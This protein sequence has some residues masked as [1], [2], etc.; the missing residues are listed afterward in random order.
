[1][2][3]PVP[4]EATV[5][6]IAIGRPTFDLA[7]A[8]PVTE[9][10]FDDLRS[11][12]RSAIGGP[13]IHT[14]ARQVEDSVRQW[15]D[16]VDT[17]VVA[18]STFADSTL[19]AAAVAGLIERAGLRIVLWSF[20]ERRRSSRLSWN[21]LCGS[22]LAAF[23]FHSEPVIVEAVHGTPA[24]ATTLDRLAAALDPAHP[25]PDRRPPIPSPRPTVED[26]QLA[27]QVVA[28]LDQARIGIIGRPPDGFEPCRVTVDPSPVGARFETVDLD[29]LFAAASS[30][31]GSGPGPGVEV[32]LDPRVRSLAEIEQR[33]PGGVGR[34]LRLHD[35]LQDITG[36]RRWDGLA[37]RCWP[38]CFTEWGSA[39]CGPLSF[40]SESGIPGACEADGYG[41]LTAL[42]LQLVA[43]R[44]AFLADLVDID[45]RGNTGVFW[46]CGVAPTS[47]ADPHRPVAAIDHPNRGVPL[48][49]GFGLA[50]GPVTIAR[51]SQTG[52]RLR[53][54]VGFGD[55]LDGAGPFTGTSG[56]VRFQRPVEQLL[57]TIIDEGLEHHFVLVPGDHRPALTAVARRWRM[58]VLHLTA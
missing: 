51:I 5:A 26:E 32:R 23:R 52:D 31:A 58:P 36:E 49:L 16:T 10:A 4:S 37:L 1:M 29:R 15:P 48:A 14:A 3:G 2:V 39:A 9:Q 25:S 35:A 24:T 43:G 13:I 21:S 50:P 40:L 8:K 45:P 28:R 12:H 20:P 11:L 7:S 56:T 19:P 17:V 30:G 42:L 46:H 47:M 41:A 53:L 54:V 55:V 6:M 22:I 57:S 18:F 27:Q 38:E 34:S 44:P 33:D